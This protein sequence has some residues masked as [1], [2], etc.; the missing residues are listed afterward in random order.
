MVGGLLVVFCMVVAV[1][2]LVAVWVL[3]VVAWLLQLWLCCFLLGAGFGV[4]VVSV[5]VLFWLRACLYVLAVGFRWFR[6][7]A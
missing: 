4:W 1:L 7:V 3:G 6:F 2:Y 5:S